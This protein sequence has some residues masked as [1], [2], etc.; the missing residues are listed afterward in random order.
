MA[1]PFFLRP[2]F[3]PNKWAPSAKPS[4]PGLTYGMAVRRWSAAR[5][6]LAH[7]TI[8]S[9]AAPHSLDPATASKLSANVNFGL[10]V[11][12]ARVAAKTA[13]GSLTDAGMLEI[14]LLTR[15][16]ARDLNKAFGAIA[17]WDILHL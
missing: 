4:A 2:W 9:A 5:M 13:N 10:E 7:K 6:T 14:V 17:P 11:I 12:K 8:M 16:V 3:G 1:L 15:A